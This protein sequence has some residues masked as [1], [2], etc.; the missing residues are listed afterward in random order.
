MLPFPE[1]FHRCSETGFPSRPFFQ[2]LRSSRN[3]GP[4]SSPNALDTAFS[5][6]L[7]TPQASSMRALEGDL[8]LSSYSGFQK[9]R[10]APLSLPSRS[11]VPTSFVGVSPFPNDVVSR[12][13]RKRIRSSSIKR[14][15]LLGLLIPTEPHRSVSCTST[16][17]ERRV[18]TSHDSPKW[19][20]NVSKETPID[21]REGERGSRKG[22]TER[23]E[24]FLIRKKNVSSS[25][26]TFVI[27][28]RK[29]AIDFP[30]F[31]GRR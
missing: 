12:S 26:T 20:N 17:G 18:T 25:I 24:T 5:T 3:D 6:P 2:T 31:R 15:A 30:P 10:I 14:T 29:R 13:L 9:R 7:V 21:V 22:L 11:Q 16:R 23:Y 27:V 4:I 8:E 1:S 28:S 19:S